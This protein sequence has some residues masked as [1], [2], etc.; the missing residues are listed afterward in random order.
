LSTPQ[1]TIS[2]RGNKIISGTVRIKY[3]Y[4]KKDIFP[5]YFRKNAPISLFLKKNPVYSTDS[6]SSP[7][8]PSSSPDDRAGKG[9]PLLN[10]TSKASRTLS[11]IF[12]RI[13]LLIGCAIS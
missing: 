6:W 4:I 12:F 10:S 2:Y 13:S 8:S 9:P 3:E 5:G 7:K 1:Y 11:S